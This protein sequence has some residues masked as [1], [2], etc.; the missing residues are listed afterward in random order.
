MAKKNEGPVADNSTGKLKLKEKKSKQPN[1]DKAKEGVT[2][3]NEKLKMKPEII[4]ESVVK[5]DL[6]K[7]IK[8]EENETKE[9][10]ADDS[11]VVASTENAD[12]TEKTRRSTTGSRSTRNSS[13]KRD[14]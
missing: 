3:V 5:V 7:P 9:D 13:T 1:K 8:P 14:Y 2:K 4:E 6:N 12:A 11:G 10:N